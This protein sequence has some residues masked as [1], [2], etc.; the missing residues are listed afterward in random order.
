MAHRLIEHPPKKELCMPISSAVQ[1]G[2]YVHVYDEKGRNVC[3]KP[4]GNGP[5]DGLTGYTSET[6]TVRRGNKVY[7]Y[8]DKGRNL[9]E[10]NAGGY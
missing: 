8:D 9:F 3:Q 7:T 5:N 2:S 1:K 10:R 6:F 4:A